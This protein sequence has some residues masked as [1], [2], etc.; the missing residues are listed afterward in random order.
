MLGMRQHVH[1]GTHDTINHRHQLHGTLSQQKHTQPLI[2]TRVIS[3]FERW[4]ENVRD[5]NEFIAI[6]LHS[7]SDKTRENSACAINN[8]AIYHVCESRTLIPDA[9]W[10][11]FVLKCIRVC[12][13]SARAFLLTSVHLHYARA[14]V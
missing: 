14:Y 7:L 10:R 5:N 4:R 13:G 1:S 2:Q 9:A 12:G 11:N 8:C 3:L 6:Q